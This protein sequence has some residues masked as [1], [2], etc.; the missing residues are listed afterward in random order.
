MRKK[1]FSVQK[2]KNKNWGECGR[3][4]ARCQGDPIGRI[5]GVW[6]IFFTVV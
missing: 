4:L 5:L 6:A 1:F 3:H 2:S